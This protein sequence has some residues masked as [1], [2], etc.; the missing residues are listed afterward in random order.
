M[1]QLTQMRMGMNLVPTPDDVSRLLIAGGFK[2]QSDWPLVVACEE[3][4]K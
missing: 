3:L 1:E 4:M 2:D